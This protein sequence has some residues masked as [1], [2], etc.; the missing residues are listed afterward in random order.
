MSQASKKK[1]KETIQFSSVE[2]E[3]KL[4]PIQNLKKIQWIML[5]TPLRIGIETKKDRLSQQ[6]LQKIPKKHTDFSL[7]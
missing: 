3:L 4:K 2:S 7:D 1:G 5:P 6:A